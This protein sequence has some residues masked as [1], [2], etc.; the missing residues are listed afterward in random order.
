M[1]IIIADYYKKKINIH[2]IDLIMS[3]NNY[4]LYN[5][6]NFCYDKNGEIKW[7]DMLYMNKSLQKNSL[8]YLR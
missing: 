7:F 3:K 4:Y 2:D 6:E 5:M 8:K 1:E